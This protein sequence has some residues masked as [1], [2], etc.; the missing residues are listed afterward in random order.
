MKHVA[1]QS[2]VILYGSQARG[3]AHEDSDIDLLILVD[4]DKLS[5]Q[6]QVAITDPLFDLESQYNYKIAISPLVYTRQQWYNRPFQTPFY[7][8]VMN[9]GIKL[10]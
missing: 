5:Y 2:E 6:E 7:L 4:K 8:N 9:E 3:D 10:L 1:P